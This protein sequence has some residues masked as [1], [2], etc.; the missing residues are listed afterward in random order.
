MTTPESLERLGRR[1]A[2]VQ[3]GWL[4]R[5]API[6]AARDGFLLRA[7]AA[8]RGRSVLWLA[9]A[10]VAV[11]AVLGVGAIIGPRAFWSPR[12]VLALVH[13]QP[14]TP[15][16]WIQSEPAERLPID[17]SDG[18]RI[19][20]EPGSRV[21]IAELRANGATL[22]VEAGS[23]DVSVKHQQKTDYRLSLGPFLVRVTGTRFNVSFS[24]DRDLLRLTMREGT[25]VVS[26]CALGDPRPLRAG[27]SLT[28]SCRDN[29]FEIS[30]GGQT[31]SAAPAAGQ[32]ATPGEQSTTPTAPI[33]ATRDSAT[34]LS[35]RTPRAEE[36]S[37]QA[38]ARAGKF[39]K[40]LASVD[41]AS[42]FSA[43][44]ERASGD[45]LALLADM[46]RLNSRPQQAIYALTALRRRF[47]G[48]QRASLAAFNIARVHFDQRGA[49]DE[50]ARW[51]RT[52]LREQPGGALVREAQG[53][54]MEALYRAGDRDS[55][56]RV[57]ESYLNANPTG[58]YARFARSLLG[59]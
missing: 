33:D 32:A 7:G 19:T 28:A 51:F 2:S 36:L 34:R 37:W 26:G 11:G 27:E 30:R 59:R 55:A 9:V 44:C 8:S 25:V 4:E 54:L 17:F 41:G 49:Y 18:S 29:H 6:E 47:P 52:Y 40:A 46:A 50:A 31:A 16:S 21:R 24:P 10:A 14:A 58:P 56:Q 15:N 48:S 23:L 22:A 45:D 39:D 57:A 13:T 43:E 5:A 35:A 1:V 20:L 38:L 12:P 42:G 53:R 3:D